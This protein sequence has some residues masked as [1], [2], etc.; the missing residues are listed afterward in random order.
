MTDQNENSLAW[1]KKHKAKRRAHLRKW[2]YLRRRVVNLSYSNPK[3]SVSDLA[4]LI[5]D[6]EIR[7]W[8]II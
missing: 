3:G 4:D 1:Q 5:L 7:R 8:S 2:Y 6:A